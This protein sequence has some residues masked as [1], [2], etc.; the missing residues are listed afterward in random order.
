M[1]VSEAAYFVLAQLWKNMLNLPEVLVGTVAS[2]LCVRKYAH[3]I[4]EMYG[5]W[6]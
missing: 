2:H 1:S 5:G 3:H 4:I 6:K